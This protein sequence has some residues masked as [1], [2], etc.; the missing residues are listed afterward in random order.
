MPAAP[1]HYSRTE[2]GWA[3]SLLLSGLAHVALLSLGLWAGA[4]LARIPFGGQHPG[5]AGGTAIQASLVSK[6]PGGSVPMPA[7]TMQDTRNR[8]ANNVPGMTK[9]VPHPPP[10]PRAHAVRLPAPTPPRFNLRRQA[11]AELRRMQQAEVRRRQHRRAM[12]GAGGPASFTYS[13]SGQGVGGGGGMSFGDAT[14][15]TLYTAWVNQLRNRLGYYW[16]QQYRDPS[17]PVGRPVF[18]VFSLNRSGR[19]Y[20]IGFGRRSGIGALDGMALHAVQ[21]MA[22]S[23][24]FPL[25]AGYGPATLNVAVSFEL[26]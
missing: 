14:F 6:I 20:G 11:A 18:I 24:R 17:A 12:Y 3:G 19:I 7:P 13:M 22:A 9:T 1:S 15:G 16:N 8:L 2:P 23:E 25:P 26:Q 5:G 10:R 4:W 21:Q